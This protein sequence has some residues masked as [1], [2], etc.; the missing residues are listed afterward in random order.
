MAQALACATAGSQI[1]SASVVDAMDDWLNIVEAATLLRKFKKKDGTPSEGAVRNLVYRGLIR[2]YKP[3]G[4]L[5]FKKSEL[6]RQIVLSER[7]G[8]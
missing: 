3:F 4:R 5:L 2:A 8:R 1:S 7:K 6:V